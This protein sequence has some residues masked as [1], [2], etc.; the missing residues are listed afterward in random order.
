MET[1]SHLRII[2]Q[3]SLLEKHYLKSLSTDS[4]FADEYLKIKDIVSKLN[5]TD[6]FVGSERW[7][8]SILY[9]G[10]F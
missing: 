7:R 10:I 2:N 1:I 3:L 9:F 4:S 8:I 5:I 6:G